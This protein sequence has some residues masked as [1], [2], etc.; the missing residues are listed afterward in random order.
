MLSLCGAALAA[1]SPP[2][3]RAVTHVLHEKRA[4]DPVDW[5]ISHRLDPDKVLPMR[6]GLTQSNLHRVEE[7]LMEVSHPESAKYGQHYTP[8]EVVDLFA[9]SDETISAVTNWLVE[10]GIARDRLRISGNKGWL[11]VH[12]TTAEVEDLLKTEYHVYTHPSGDQQ[13][14]CHNYSVPAHVREHID[15]I[16]PTVQFNHR[17]TPQNGL[18]KRMG[19]LG[20][21]NGRNG[22]K[23]SDKAVTITPSLDNCDTLIT[24]DCLRAL[25]DVN[26][27][28][29]AT[30][31][32]SR[33][34]NVEF[35]P[36]AFLGPDL[37]LFFGNFSPSLVGVRPVNVLIDGA[38]VQT[39]QQ[40]FDFNGESDLDLEYA[41]GLTAPQTITL[42]QTGDIVEGAGFDNWLDA[43]DGSFCT[44]EGGDDPTQDG[45]YPD[46]AKGGFKGPESCGIV[47]PQ[48]VVSV[49]YG[50]D[51]AS[52]TP[53][54]ANRQC[55]EYAKLGMLGTTVLYS[56]G[57][58]GVA[59]GGGVCL[60]AKHQTSNRGTVFNP[61]FPVTCPFLTAVGATQVNPGSTVNDPEG[62]CEQVIFSGGGFSNIFPMP[63]YQAAAVSGFLT[64]H[65][66]PFT[67]AQFNNSGT[68]RGFPDLS[69]NGANY[70]IGIDG[71]F[72]LVFGTS[73][74][75]PVVGSL[76]TLINDARLAAG[77][78]SVG[79]INPSIYSSSFA[80]AFNDIT[81]G[82][83]Q[84]CGTAGFTATTGWDPVTGE[85]IVLFPP[86]WALHG[87]LGFINKTE[88]VRLIFS[89]S[90]TSSL[91]FGRPSY[92]NSA[93]SPLVTPRIFLNFHNSQNHNIQLALD[94]DPP[95]LVDG[96]SIS[97]F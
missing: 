30:A 92:L 12:A 84:G 28:P 82:G 32:N 50:Q 18:R 36:Q 35:T 10:A 71:A 58:D 83:N 5:E 33:D 95:S 2:S 47:A 81:S 43:V 68:V 65:K 72:S 60:N 13:F 7:L 9:P 67:A 73:A 80:S 54:F 77:K 27:T 14:G 91:L 89:Y 90:P 61:G 55:T 63:S 94:V 8:S 79:F 37:D 3:R 26:Y 20:M 25:Y 76:I 53:A 52:V 48:F 57:D 31:K 87:T 34:A 23:K 96:T 62:A 78:K 86:C 49:S 93:L 19:G 85:Y 46:T 4:M 59:G 29:V 75:S 56:S 88:Y 66:P 6:F 97:P 16:R 15:L 69:A 24:L 38:V 51:E 17:A 21:P 41:M 64:N 70:V 44:F 42:L 45:I 1:P 11:S 22:P 39:T 74:S 40:S